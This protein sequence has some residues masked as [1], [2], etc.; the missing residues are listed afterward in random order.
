MSHLAPSALFFY[1]IVAAGPVQCLYALVMALA[2]IEGI[3][4]RCMV[5]SQI[6]SN[7]KC[8]DVGILGSIDI[9]CADSDPVFNLYY[10][11][12]CFSSKMCPRNYD[13]S[14]VCGGGGGGGGGGE[15]VVTFGRHALALVYPL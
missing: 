1:R 9:P 7:F 13:W 4:T 15:G 5:S 14:S 11:M 10:P 12:T 8:G 3:A 2:D 6:A